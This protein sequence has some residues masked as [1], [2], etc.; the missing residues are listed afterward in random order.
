MN[1]TA[2][3]EIVQRLKTVLWPTAIYRFRY[4]PGGP[5]NSDR[6]GINL[7]IVVPDDEEDT[8]HKSLR[9]LSSLGELRV[10]AN[11]LVRHESDF[12]KRTRWLDS[13][14]R[15]INTSGDLLYGEGRTGQGHRHF[16]PKREVAVAEHQH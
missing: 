7:C 14:E 1:A 5:G 11:L 12:R 2:P 9:A 13:L 4:P 8:Y 6:S 16:A 15:E 3:D 10:Q